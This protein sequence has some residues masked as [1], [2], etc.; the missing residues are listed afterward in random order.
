MDLI[1]YGIALVAAFAINNL[2]VK[3]DIPDN[4]DFTEVVQQ[5]SEIVYNGAP[6]EFDLPIGNNLAL[7]KELDA[8]TLILEQLGLK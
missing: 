3:S 1:I 6:I 8:F 5:Q 2:R 4:I 7:N